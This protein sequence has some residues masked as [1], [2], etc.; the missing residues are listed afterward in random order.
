MGQSHTEHWKKSSIDTVC[1]YFS[2]NVYMHFKWQ[3]MMM[4]T[5][6]STASSATYKLTFR[7]L[8]FPWRLKNFQATVLF[9]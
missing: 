5:E 2:V 9:H 1:T 4:V 6:G 3:L 8:D 7:F